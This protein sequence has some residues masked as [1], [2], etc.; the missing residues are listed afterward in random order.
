MIKNKIIDDYLDW[1]YCLVSDDRPN[2]NLSYRSLFQLL[3][4]T[5]FTYVMSMDENRAED[6]RDLR[7]RFC[8]ET[9]YDRE[10]A[11]YY[12]N[13]YPCSVL[14]MM[15]AL[16]LRCEEHIMDNPDIGNR[17]GK[18]FWDMINSLRLG[19]MND[20]RFDADYAKERLYTFLYRR[21]QHNGAGGLFIVNNPN[22]DMRT[23]EIWYQMHYYLNEISEN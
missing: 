8:Y 14:E 10:R 19:F 15:I 3:Y 20:K 1:M 12:L 11:C 23:I 21:Y 4:E 16:A 5:P 7:Y 9:H 17:T 6:G 2:K 18:W 22:Y 13:T